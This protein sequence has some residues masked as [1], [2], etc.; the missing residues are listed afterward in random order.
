MNAAMAMAER[1]LIMTVP[2]HWAFAARR[3]VGVIDSQRRFP[4]VFAASGN[5]FVAPE[6]CFVGLDRDETLSVPR[7]RARPPKWFRAGRK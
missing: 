2:C 7:R 5:G 4:D 6:F 1:A 3:F